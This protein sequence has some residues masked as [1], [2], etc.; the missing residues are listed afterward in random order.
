MRELS[1]GQHRFTTVKVM[2]EPGQG[3]ACHE[4][5]IDRNDSPLNAPAGE[6][7]YIRFQN[8]PVQE[9]GVR[10]LLNQSVMK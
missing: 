3:N 4:Y 2:D 10:C 1:I 7:G 8:G 5:A 9:S 6:Y